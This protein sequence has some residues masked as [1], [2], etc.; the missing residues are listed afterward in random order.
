MRWALVLLVLL[1]CAGIWMWSPLRELLEPR[2]IG[3]WLA[4]FRH[5]PWAPL[6]VLAVF[7]AGG[8]LMLPVTLMVVL[9]AVAFGPVLGFV[10]ALLASTASA[11]VSFLIGRRLGH[12]HVEQLAGTRVHNLSRRIGHHGFL[13]IALLRM[14]PVAHFTVVSMAAGTSHIRIA[15]FLAGTLAGMAPG[16]IV[17]IAFLDSLAAA[18]RQPD[19]LRIAVALALGLGLVATLLVLRHW[20]RRRKAQRERVRSQ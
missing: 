1:L 15:S 12:R 20:L 13:T 7:I 10:Y 18:A 5:E 11:G 3:A 2:E 19:P 14:V 17:L 8:L 4:R 6:A 16:M 9:T